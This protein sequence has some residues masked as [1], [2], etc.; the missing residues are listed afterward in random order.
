MVGG[1]NTARQG[2]GGGWLGRVGGGGEELGAGRL[3]AADPVVE[4]SWAGD[5]A[6][7]VPPEMG[8]TGRRRES[9]MRD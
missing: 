7:E 6:A 3:V 8:G 9:N 2:G 5:P 4:R 1:D